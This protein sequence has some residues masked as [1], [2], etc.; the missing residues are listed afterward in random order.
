MN[1]QEFKDQNPAYKDWDDKELADGLHGKYYADVPVKDFY[2]VIGFQEAAAPVASMKP[3]STE[4]SS[5]LSVDLGPGLPSEVRSNEPDPEAALR[6]EVDAY[7]KDNSFIE[8]FAARSARGISQRQQGKSLAQA[9]AMAQ[10]RSEL[11]VSEKLER[12]SEEEFDEGVFQKRYQSYLESVRQESLTQKEIPMHPAARAALERGS[13]GD[14][15]GMWQAFGVDPVGVTAEIGVPSLYTSGESMIAAG[16]VGM[17]T[18]SVELA[19]SAMG[20]GSYVTDIQFGISEG[21]QAKGINLEDP[22]EVSKALRDP[23]VINEIRQS[24]NLHA[25]PVGVV[26]AIG[27]KLAAM[28]LAPKRMSINAREAVNVG[29]QLAA[30]P[31][32]GVIGETAGQA[33]QGKGFDIGQI[34]AEAI[35]EFV[36]APAEVGAASVGGYRELTQERRLYR[37][38]E[39]ETDRALARHFEGL[40]SPEE[41]A[42]DSL[43]PRGAEAQRQQ[44]GTVVGELPKVEVNPEITAG[45][46]VAGAMVAGPEVA[47]AVAIAR[48]TEQGFEAGKVVEQEL[49]D[50]PPAQKKQ[51]LQALKKGLKDRSLKITEDL[52][53]LSGILTTKGKELAEPGPDS[54]SNMDAIVESAKR[55]SQI[56]RSSQGIS[57]QELLDRLT[58]ATSQ[59]TFATPAGKSGNPRGGSWLEDRLEKVFRG[60][61]QGAQVGRDRSRREQLE[62]FVREYEQ[63]QSARARGV[64]F[65][66]NAQ[67]SRLSQNLEQLRPGDRYSPRYTDQAVVE[68]AAG[69]SS[70][71]AQEAERANS[72]AKRGKVWVTDGQNPVPGDPVMSAKGFEIARKV[73]ERWLARVYPGINIVL[74]IEYLSNPRFNAEVGAAL[75]NTFK[76]SVAPNRENLSA[77]GEPTPAFFEHLAHEVGHAVASHIFMHSTVAIQQRLIAEWNRH[78]FDKMHTRIVD[79]YSSERGIVSGSGFHSPATLDQYVYEYITTRGEAAAFYVTYHTNMDEWL[80]HQ[81]ELK[82]SA[83]DKGLAAPLRAFVSKVY[84]AYRRLWAIAKRDYQPNQT[85]E[86]FL[87]F[88]KAAALLES[89]IQEETI[90]QEIL[91]QIEAKKAIPQPKLKVASQVPPVETAGLSRSEARVAARAKAGI[92]SQASAN[93][94]WRNI[95][96]V[97]GPSPQPSGFDAHLDSFTWIKRWT[98]TLLHVARSNPHIKELSDPMGVADPI[99]GE[100]RHG[101]LDYILKW[102]ALRMNWVSRADGRLKEWRRLGA[103]D[104]ALLSRFMLEQTVGGKRL[105]LQDPAVLQQYPLSPEAQE[106]YAKID[107]DFKDYISAMEETL[108]RE[109]MKRLANNPFVQNEIT[110]LR[111]QFADLRSRPYFP[112]TRFGRYTVIV[113]AT[114]PGMSLG[115]PY[116]VGDTIHFEA[117]D[118]KA[119]R[120]AALGGISRAFP[121]GELKLD[122]MSEGMQTMAGMPRPLLEALKV[123]L[124]LTPEQEKELDNYLYKTAPAQSFVK[125]LIQRKGIS[126]FTFDTRR[127]Y[128]DYFLH[129]ANHLARVTY[130][131]ALAESIQ[132]LGQTA[133]AISGDATTRRSLQNYFSRHFDYLMNP[134]SDWA[135][136]RAVIAVAYLGAVIKTAVVNLTQVPM[137]TYPHLA[138]IYGDAKALGALKRAY[139]DAIK[140]YKATRPLASWEQES[141]TKWVNGQPL[142][143][144]QQRFVDS[145]SGLSQEERD[146]LIQAMREGFIDESFAMEL[147]AMSAGSWLNKMQA[148]SQLG[149][150]MRQLTSGVMIP[151]QAAEKLNRRVTFMAGFRLARENGANYDQAFVH[152]R[153]AVSQTQFEYAK[154]NRPELLRGRKGA[155]MMFMQFQLNTLWFLAGADAGWWRAWALLLFAAGLMGL[156]FADN[157]M[158]LAEWAYQRFNPNSPAFIKATLKREAAELF[159]PQV[160]DLMLHGA[161]RYGFGLIPFADLSG[162]ISLGRVIPGTNVLFGNTGIASGVSRDWDSLATDM[163]TESGGA[164]TALMMRT[165]QMAA[166][167]DPDTWSK[168]ER[169]MPFTFGQQWIGAMKW[170]ARGGVETGSGAK[171]KEF[172]LSDPWDLAEV[173]GKALG[174]QPRSVSQERED[175]YYRQEAQR[176]YALRREMLLTSL[177]DRL[178]VHDKE[179]MKEVHL[180][181]GK[182]NAQVPYPILKLGPETVKRSMTQRLKGNAMTENVDG[183]SKQEIVIGR[184]LRPHPASPPVVGN[185]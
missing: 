3:S 83:N 114:Q 130:Y 139:G 121:N 179:G 146:A 55:L 149:Y 101:Y 41:L 52:K 35:G 168:I 105:D 152:G 91:A 92:P 173:A 37:K 112:L 165:I 147:A 29:S 48:A 97:L 69:Q 184:M 49:K 59:P 90:L 95:K 56:V 134:E 132:R 129:G 156:P 11:T 82:L 183:R 98:A 137:V 175:A 125:H 72:Q 13:K 73:L 51:F 169:G 8:R 109:A 85:W 126:G 159:G 177:F 167:N 158:D 86:E 57:D 4:P 89:G 58:S 103:K 26:D 123:T 118:T 9:G 107:G 42:I 28:T 53:R 1:L 63:L 88:G 180:A 176:Y 166:S 16:G 70:S 15:K 122:Q 47:A 80:A 10:P 75:S 138:A 182:Y 77:T 113:K 153:D 141:I 20:F 124:K 27:A 161:S 135:A 25:I 12:P 104:S 33:A 108:V 45:E 84:Q 148:G 60:D 30:Q 44:K 160:G 2:K 62:G 170:Y 99:T 23:A 117:F 5:A 128:S 157:L 93:D 164:T 22:T 96:D 143:P 39:L 131:Q 144:K 74:S 40:P 140:M 21:L 185:E 19:A 145:W 150:R 155:F 65:P 110:R 120:K 36:T 46:Q 87:T 171:I 154:W 136:A 106:L 43:D 102:A 127:A 172:D 181:I 142:T 115:K 7:N 111:Q 78:L 163:V 76:I 67:G 71:V 64:F 32:T 162:S 79:Y 6:A 133:T 119:E 68:S 54:T 100:R 31:L 61:V 174:F 66:N 24:A 38:L 17:L 18:K 116:K 94:I 34:A 178:R 81:M 14:A 50:F 151:F